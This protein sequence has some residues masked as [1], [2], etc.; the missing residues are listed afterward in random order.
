M[1]TLKENALA[2]L[3]MHGGSC[4]VLRG[5][6]LWE[7]F[8]NLENSGE[9]TTTPSSTTGYVDIYSKDFQPRFANPQE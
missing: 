3:T 8:V 5:S 4:S 2:F 9:V 6:K 1:N 7:G